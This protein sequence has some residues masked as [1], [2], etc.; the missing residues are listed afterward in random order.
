M[1]RIWHIKKKKPRTL[2]KE[3]KIGRDKFFLSLKA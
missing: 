1:I 3:K 2:V